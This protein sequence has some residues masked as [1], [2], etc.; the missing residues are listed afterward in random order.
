MSK[1]KRRSDESS[2]VEADL[3]PI[4]SCMFLLIPALLLGMEIARTTVVPV[5]PPRVSSTPGHTSDTEERFDFR[6]MVRGDGFAT[7]YGSQT[8]TETDIPMAPDAGGASEHDFEALTA[9]AKSLK[10][11]VPKEVTVRLTAEGDVELQTLIETMDAVRG[12][13]CS[14]RPIMLGEK[15]S[16]DCLFWNV[17]V[18]S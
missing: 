3:I 11:R 7:S 12:Q 1:R 6:V 16:N 4:L 17:I 14:L 9:L 13:D 10:A 2:S 15:G 8:R 18:E 5:S